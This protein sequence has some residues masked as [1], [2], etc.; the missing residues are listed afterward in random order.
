[1]L[2]C[3]LIQMNQ[4]KLFTQQV[5]FGILKLQ[6]EFNLDILKIYLKLH[7]KNNLLK[8]G[9]T[10]SEVLITLVIIG[11]IA[12]ITI[13]AVKQSLEN[14]EYKIQY[15]K[16]HSDLSNAVLQS[17]AFGE[18]PLREL[19]YDAEV[20]AEEWEIIKKSF[21]VQKLCENNNIYECWKEA[22]YLWNNAPTSSSKSF[23][24]AS[25]RVWALFS[26]SEAGYMVDVNGDKGPN[27]FGKDRWGFTFAGS[28]GKRIC[29][30]SAS[31][32]DNG[33]LSGNAGYPTKVIPFIYRD[34]TEYDANECHYPPCYYVSWLL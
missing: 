23:V 2:N 16:A 31:K 29:T 9:F 5:Y 33:C 21:S 10:L 34:I 3:I 13:P 28:D 1:M 18:F 27:K 26:P 32:A 20:T 22:D 15:K 14:T 6:K 7:S 8:N 25:G 30:G 4:I 19:K 17:V 24:D 12:A 11:V